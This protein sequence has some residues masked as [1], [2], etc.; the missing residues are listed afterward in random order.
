MKIS[1]VDND[2]IEQRAYRLDA[3]VYDPD[4]LSILEA[5]SNYPNKTNIGEYAN[6][7]MPG[8]FK[9]YRTEI[10]EN[11]VPFLTAS[12]ILLAKPQ[13]VEFLSKKLHSSDLNILHPKP[14]TILVTR[15][16]TIGNCAMTTKMLAEFSISEDAIR[17][18]PKTPN[19]GG[20]LYTYL[21]SQVGQTLLVRDK[22]GSVID[23]IEPFHIQNLLIPQLP[24]SEIHG[25]EK[26]IEAA[27]NKRDRA[28]QLLIRLN[29]SFNDLLGLPSIKHSVNNASPSIFH[30]HSSEFDFRLDASYYDPPGREAVQILEKRTDCQLLGRVT[31]RIFHPFRMNMIMVKKEFGVP[32]L[33]GGDIVQ[34][35]YYSDKYISPVTDNYEEYLLH[36]N[37]TLM[38]IGGTIGRITYVGDYL[39]RASASQHVTRIVPDEDQLL[40]G[41]LCAFMESEYAQNQVRNLIY[42]SVVDTIRESQL[43][44]LHIPVP[45]FDIQK[46]IHDVVEEAY[47]LRYEANNLE[48]EAQAFLYKAIGL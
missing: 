2:R 17:V 20:Y 36:R 16:G 21:S 11:G 4:V 18:E 23:H 40:P 6:V 24:S 15:S 48:D 44:S 43:E 33:G 25:F 29:S 1:I 32:F 19:S 27:W 14:G 10:A 39:D 35:R 37:W 41:Y 5:I 28:N 30:I 9:R 13:K 22:Y 26:Y 31:K 3:S 7:W 8:R 12:Q 45:S 47:K 42:G 34:L 46:P 38:T